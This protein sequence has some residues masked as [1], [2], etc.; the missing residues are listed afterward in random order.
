MV[1][2]FDGDPF[3][4]PILNFYIII[5]N[6]H[7]IINTKFSPWLYIALYYYQII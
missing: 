6:Y 1:G 5:K 3:C 7:K 4:L 2:N